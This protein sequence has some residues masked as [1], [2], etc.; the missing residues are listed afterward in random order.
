MVEHSAARQIFNVQRSLGVQDGPPESSECWLIKGS[1]QRFQH[2]AL[3]RS[4]SCQITGKHMADACS[5]PTDFV[6]YPCLHAPGCTQR[7]KAESRLRVGDTS[8]NKRL[9]WVSDRALHRQGTRVCLKISRL[10]AT[11]STVRT[12]RY[13]RLFQKES[14]SKNEM[15]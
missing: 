5:N 15:A 4:N 9:D 8:Y 1:Q 13:P 11:K 12:S 2:E 6:I 7:P 10:V 14:R 3:V